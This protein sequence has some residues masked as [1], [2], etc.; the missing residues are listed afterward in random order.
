MDKNV[1]DS[2]FFCRWTP[3]CTPFS[4]KHTGENIA[5]VVDLDLTEKLELPTSLPMWGV[6]DNASNMVKGLNL[7]IA[8]LYT[9]LCHTQQLAIG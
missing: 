3:Y 9:C 4:D 7:S 1:K 6:A 5:S 2:K 8:D